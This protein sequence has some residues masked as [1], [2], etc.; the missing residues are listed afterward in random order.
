MTPEDQRIA[1]AEACGWKN[2]TQGSPDDPYSGWS[3]NCFPQPI[4]NLPDY[5]NDLNAA[6]EMEKALSEFEFVDYSFH[7][8]KITNTNTGQVVAL[9]ELIHATATQRSEAFLK[10]K[11]L[12]KP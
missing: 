1:I 6:H 2:V 8:S 9:F 7:V 12:W 4:E 5:L 11:G 3:N 10:T